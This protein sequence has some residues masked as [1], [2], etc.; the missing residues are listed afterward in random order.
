[1]DVITDSGAQSVVW[2]REEFNKSG[3]HA[4]DLIPVHHA[5]KAVNA[6]RISIDG[7]ILLRLVGTT[8]D[9]TKVEAAVMAYI[10]PDVKD[11]FLSK[12]AMI[13]L[14]IINRDFPQV[15]AP[16]GIRDTICC[17]VVVDETEFKNRMWLS[18]T[19]TPANSTRIPSIPMSPRES[20]Q[21][22]AVAPGNVRFFD[23]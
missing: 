6:A 21:N 20:L 23:F 3:F 12:E 5:M 11:F 1:M 4:S 15:A 2:S 8:K 22:E 18:Q 10:S 7:A 16:S 17:Q 19:P 9:G 13:Q 14:G